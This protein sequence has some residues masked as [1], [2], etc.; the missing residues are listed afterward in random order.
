MVN[1]EKLLFERQFCKRLLKQEQ[2]SIVV[3][4]RKV[5]YLKRELC[6]IE[7]KIKR[8]LDESD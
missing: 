6:N 2:T 7:T 1:I 4:R 3:N 8:K 5:N